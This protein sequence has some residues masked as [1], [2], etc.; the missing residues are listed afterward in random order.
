MSIS[1]IIHK[2]I[3]KKLFDFKN[4]HKYTSHYQASFDNITNLLNNNSSYI[5]KSTEIYIQAIMLMNIETDYC[6]L[7][8]TIHKD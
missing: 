1:R 4:I 5:C 7:V 6:V 2:A 3:T 8:L